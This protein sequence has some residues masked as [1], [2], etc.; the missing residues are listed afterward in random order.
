M[1]LM[2]YLLAVTCLVELA[3]SMTHGSYFELV[4]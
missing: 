3:S 2:A 4:R 1:E